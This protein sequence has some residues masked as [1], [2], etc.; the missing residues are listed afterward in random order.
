M[1]EIKFELIKCNMHTYSV[2]TRT[3]WKGNGWIDKK[4]Y[5]LLCSAETE[6]RGGN[7]T[8]FVVL[9]MLDQVK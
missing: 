1:K 8:D 4:E 7:G 6:K 2:L 5:T 3:R 9:K